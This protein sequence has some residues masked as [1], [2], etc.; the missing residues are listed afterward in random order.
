MKSN[1]NQKSLSIEDIDTNYWRLGESGG[2]KDLW[3]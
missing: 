3:V 1:Q 2:H